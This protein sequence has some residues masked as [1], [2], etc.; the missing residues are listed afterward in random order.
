MHF[1]NNLARIPDFALYLLG[2][3]TA[4]KSKRKEGPVKFE[5]PME[6][7]FAVSY[8]KELLVFTIGLTYSSIGTAFGMSI[9]QYLAPIVLPF[10]AIYFGFSY[11]VNRHNWVYVI[12]GPYEGVKMTRIVIDRI[13]VAIIL[14]QLTTLGVLGLGVCPL[15]VLFYIHIL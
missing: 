9:L 5:W 10:A 3:I 1:L 13:F 2:K 6:L 4:D 8:T 14:Y 7:Y 11:F 12:D 15:Y